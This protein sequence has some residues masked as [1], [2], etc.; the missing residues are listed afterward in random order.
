MLTMNNHASLM[1]DRLHS[2][3]RLNRALLSL[4]LL[5]VDPRQDWDLDRRKDGGTL[6]LLPPPLPS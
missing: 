3:S 5:L 4:S 2:R 6:L 1:M